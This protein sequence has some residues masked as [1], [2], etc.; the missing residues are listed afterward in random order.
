M[1]VIVPYIQM[2]P[3][4]K[5]A[6]RACVCLSSGYFLMRTSFLRFV[7]SFLIG[8]LFVLLYR[9]YISVMHV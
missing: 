7:T 3:Y 9:A 1:S 6:V 2:L 4:V 5:S 8:P